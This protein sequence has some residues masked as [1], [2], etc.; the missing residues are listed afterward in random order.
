MQDEKVDPFG[1]Y[2]IRFHRN[3][4]LKET[5]LVGFKRCAP[6]GPRVAYP[7]DGTI[8]QELFNRKPCISNNTTQ[9][10]CID[11][12]VA[13]NGQDALTITHNDVFALTHNS[14]P[15]LFKRAYCVKVIDAGNL[16][17]S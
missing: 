7:R 17:Q 16:G 15:G 6:H 1:H 3:D 11:R 2:F 4:F 8:D 9:G 13:R 5:H 10:K 12:V 14:K